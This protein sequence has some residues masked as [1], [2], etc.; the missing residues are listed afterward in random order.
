MSLLEGALS[1]GKGWDKNNPVT[2]IS[3]NMYQSYVKMI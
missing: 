2:A 1:Y 3:Q